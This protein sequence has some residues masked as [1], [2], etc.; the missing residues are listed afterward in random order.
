M[1]SRAGLARLGAAIVSATTDCGLR[2]AAQLMARRIAGTLGGRPRLLEQRRVVCAD[3]HQVR[4][5]T[6]VQF[7]KS[8]M[9]GLY[10]LSVERDEGFH[11]RQRPR[12]WCPVE[13]AVVVERIACVQ[14]PAMAC[15]DGHT[16][17]AA[18]VTGKRNE[19]NAR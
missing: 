1:T 19:R 15:V 10:R 11:C 13:G 16:G 17:M 8:S 14:H 4:L 18:S 12:H 2:A 5:A 9:V 6:L 7:D 3:D